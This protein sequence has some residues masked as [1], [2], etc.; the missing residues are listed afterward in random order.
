MVP[1]LL[2]LSRLCL[3]LII[4]GLGLLIWKAPRRR[5]NRED[6]PKG[7]PSKIRNGRG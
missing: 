1:V 5:R 6:W 3:M 4:L 2:I 7:G